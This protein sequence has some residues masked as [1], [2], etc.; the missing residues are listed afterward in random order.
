[1]IREVMASGRVQVYESHRETNGRDYITT[2]Q[3]LDPDH[4]L[5]TG[6]D[7]TELKRVEEALRESRDDL[8][9]AQAV[10]HT[11]SWRLNVQKQ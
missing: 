4:Y 10:A 11:G 7:I 9:R 8:N 2:I 3:R 6:R 1:M 5:V